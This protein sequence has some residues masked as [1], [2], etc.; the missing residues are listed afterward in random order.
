MDSLITRDKAE[1]KKKGL[2]AAAAWGGTGL[3]AIAGWPFMAVAGATGAGY[4]T[5]KWFVYR[6]KRGMRF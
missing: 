3:L 4:L 5:W 2:Y 6:A 1:A